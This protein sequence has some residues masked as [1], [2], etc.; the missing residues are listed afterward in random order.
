M[1]FEIANNQ[2]SCF[3]FLRLR[4]DAEIPKLN[5]QLAALCNNSFFT[6]H[7]GNNDSN[8]TQNKEFSHTTFKFP[9][10]QEDNQNLALCF[11]HIYYTYKLYNIALDLVL[12]SL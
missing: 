4:D 5:Y 2:F 7:L 1:K 6:L 11:V 3:K 9:F 12:F 8:D 10:T